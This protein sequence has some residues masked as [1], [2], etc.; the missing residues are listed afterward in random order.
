MESWLEDINFS[1]NSRNKISFFSYEEE[2]KEVKL[3][4]PAMGV[5]ASYYKSFAES[6][7]RD[8][9]TTVATIDLRGLG[10]SS[11]RASR[12]VDFGYDTYLQDLHE[13]IQHLKTN[14]SLIKIDTLGHSLGGQI[15][16]LYASRYPTNINHITLIAT[17]LPF[18][19]ACRDS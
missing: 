8:R 18:V 14:Y 6:L 13:V 4:L 10:N 9:K 1:D 12:D 7:A 19:E 16:L 15:T 2:V 11:C 3:L 5:R 17:C